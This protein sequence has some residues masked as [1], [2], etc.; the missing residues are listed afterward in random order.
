MLYLVK[1]QS[2]DTVPIPLQNSVNAT[3]SST[4][5]EKKRVCVCKAW[6]VLNKNKKGMHKLVQAA[7]FTAVTQ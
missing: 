3:A 4:G 1:L 6:S 2:T 7:E 5:W